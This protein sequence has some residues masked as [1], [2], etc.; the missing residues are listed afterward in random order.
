M[1]PTTLSTMQLACQCAEFA[2]NFPKGLLN[3][4]LYALPPRLIV[5]SIAGRSDLPLVRGHVLTA[6]A[7]V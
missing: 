3:K 6:V 4:Y 2:A 1:R 7:N 5:A